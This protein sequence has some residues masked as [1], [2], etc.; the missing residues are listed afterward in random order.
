[1]WY[2]N[3]SLCHLCV[4]LEGIGPIRFVLI[5]VDHQLDSEAHLIEGHLLAILRHVLKLAQDRFF[6]CALILDSHLQEQ[7][8]IFLLAIRLLFDRKARA[9][10]GCLLIGH[11]NEHQLV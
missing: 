2:E 1:M 10:S 6:E 5:R 9:S 7:T 11:V 3:D 8:L 4:L